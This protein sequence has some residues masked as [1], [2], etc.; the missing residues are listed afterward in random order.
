MKKRT[1]ISLRTKIYLTMVGLL[2]L[3][4]AVYA[5]TPKFFAPYL[6]ATGVAISPSN[7][8]ATQ[9]CNQNFTS[10]DCMGNASVVGQIPF[11]NQQCIEKYVAI[12]PRQS[13]AAGFTARDVFIT[14]G[15]NIFKYSIS[16]GTITPF[17]QV[18]CPFS[19]HSSLTFD[20]EGTFG[21]K[22]IVACEN[23]PIWTVDGTGLVN[24]IASTTNAQHT[25]PTHPEGPAVVPMS[26]GPNPG[27]LGGQILV[28]D[29]D[30]NQVNAIDNLGNV[31]YN[32]FNWSLL[33][34]R[35]PI[36]KTST[37]SRTLRAHSAALRISPPV[38]SS[39]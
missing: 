33:L 31:T 10:F 30:D 24:F 4:G 5:A 16:T 28:A 18:G 22:M 25:A 6:Q 12:A 19:D 38:P 23:G 27:Q 13:V 37:L 11:G 17:A 34:G 35:L 36:R 2:A 14:E 20:K 21:N 29:E 1:K 9:W 8:Y 32:V 15:Q 3:T 26:F 7:L 39:R